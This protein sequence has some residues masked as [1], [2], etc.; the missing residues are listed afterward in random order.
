MRSHRGSTSSA[1]SVASGASSQKTLSSGH[2]LDSFLSH[3]T[4]EDNHSFHEI[5]EASD[6]KL[7]QK[8]AVLYAAEGEQAKQMA[9]ALA[10]PDIEKQFEAIEG[11]KKV[12]TWTYKNKNYIM[13]VPDGV[14]LTVAEQLEMAK[15]RM[16]IAYAN[17]RL[18]HNPFDERQSKEAIT[19]LAKTHAKGMC[20]R[21]GVDGNYIDPAL[22]GGAGGE[23]RGFGF[24]KTPSPCPGV[25]ASPLMT[26]GEI[27]G[28]P[29]RLDG[30]DTPLRPMAGPSFRISETSRRETIA[31]ELADKVCER[32]RG[33][34]AR[35]I[36]AARRNIGSPLVRS[37]LERLAS[38]SPAA[39]RL[40]STG[41]PS[42][43]GM[44][45]TPSPR[46]HG[47]GSPAGRYAHMQ[48]RRTTPS[49]QLVRRKTPGGASRASGAE[50]FATGSSVA[51]G[52]SLMTDDL[53]NIPSTSAATA[54]GRKQA[55]DFF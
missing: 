54:A 51:S 31:L 4:S 42:S 50:A 43:G 29:F 8:F 30:S 47:F 5:I 27:E 18:Q 7:R 52:K 48:Q 2:T 46:R 53:L 11:P 38:M 1:R 9:L 17:T 13:Y 34:K 10:L 28:T 44:P 33:Q 49:P 32:K 16:E 24:V 23:I 14:E 20:G 15:R 39:K 3:Y 22:N 45:A 12:E 25:D 26:W 37:T 6:R 36:E 21:I 19:E 35:A 41:R 55:A 40:A